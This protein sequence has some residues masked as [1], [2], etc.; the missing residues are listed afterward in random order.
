MATKLTIPYTENNIQP[1]ITKKTAELFSNAKTFDYNSLLTYLNNNPEV[2]I[3]STDNNKQTILH[4][5]IDSI[6]PSNVSYHKLNF[7]N[8]L[9]TAHR[10]NSDT[11]DINEDTLLHLICR[12]QLFDLIPLIYGR[13]FS[14]NITN[15]I[16]KQNIFGKTPF[17]ESIQ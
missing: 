10:I 9:L 2:S 1:V 12:K 15:L 4:S 11:L 3:S 8:K 13:S 17:L 16:S 5:I 6:D 14:S 7:I